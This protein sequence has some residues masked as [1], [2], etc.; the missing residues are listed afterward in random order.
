M[1]THTEFLVK[2]VFDSAAIIKEDFT[3]TEKDDSGDL[4]TCLDL[5]V[6]TYIID[7]VKEAYPTF[8]IVSE[9]FNSS[10]DVTDNCFVID[11]LDG[12]INFA[13][14]LPLWGIQVA[15]IEN[16]ETVCSV[17][18]LPRLGELYF[19]DPDGAWRID[20]PTADM[21]SLEHAKEISVNHRSVNKTLYLVEGGYKFPALCK[22]NDF[23]RHWRFFCCTAVNSAWTA[24][25]RLGG[26]ILRKDN[27]WDWLPGQYL[28]QQAGGFIINK[29]GAHIAANCEMMAE[30][31]LK[32]GAL[33]EWDTQQKANI[34]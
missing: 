3:I 16:K 10:E 26:T 22:L 5:A 17:I 21:L 20:H 1:R 30:L 24:C 29:K 4:V 9:E 18:Y 31:L 25:G 2:T 7:K 8:D 11:P 33:T 32:D 34:S 28:V 23:S 14:G 13:H 15:M 6:E 27:V 12:T 19:A